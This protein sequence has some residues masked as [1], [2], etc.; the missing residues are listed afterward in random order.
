MKKTIII[1][2]YLFI[3]LNTYAQIGSIEGIILHKPDST[4][5][6]GVNIIV[7]GTRK[8]ATTNLDG[9]FKID[10]LKS[11]IY[12]LEILCIGTPTIRRENVLIEID[13]TTILNI[14]IPEGNCDPEIPRICPNGNHSNNIIPIV[15]G[16]P[17]KK[18]MKKAEKGKVRLGGCIISECDPK[19]YCKIHKKSF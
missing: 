6:E 11:G 7:E 1:L 16:L 9:Y 13:S 3:S 18:L 5:L 2:T 12:N 14:G 15:Y 17:G 4:F 10:S 8:G 19:W